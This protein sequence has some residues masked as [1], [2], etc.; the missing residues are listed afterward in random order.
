M[1]GDSLVATQVPGGAVT[2]RGWGQYLNEYLPQGLTLVNSALGGESSKSFYEFGHWARVA[3]RQSSHV[4]IQFG[5]N[6]TPI[7]GVAR[8]TVPG[9]TYKAFLQRYIDE[10]RAWGGIPVLVSP[11]PRRALKPDGSVDTMVITNSPDSDLQ[12]Y[13]DAMQE[14][15]VANQVAFID[16][17][18][19]WKTL[20]EQVRL[21][22][23]VGWF[24][25]KLHLFEPGARMFSRFVAGELLRQ[26]P[27]LRIR[28]NAPFLTA[29]VATA[30]T[31]TAS[32]TGNAIF[33]R[34]LDND[35]DGDGNALRLVTVGVPT[36]GTAVA[37]GGV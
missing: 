33:I 15:A 34:V 28:G 35:A 24:D 22:G 11:P 23:S 25:G 1:I 27:A 30:D 37:H 2:Y 32:G 20:F 18:T 8:T 26:V 29:P 10:T 17:F 19:F 31:A 6:D 4:L 5:H 7:S 14:V 12:L 16:L 36:K 9:T 3:A 13:R 21:P